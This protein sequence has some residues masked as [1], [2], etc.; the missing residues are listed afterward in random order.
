[1]NI[2]S[3][4]CTNGWKPTDSADSASGTVAGWR[5][6]ALSRLAHPRA[7]RVPS[8]GAPSWWTAST[9][10]DSSGTGAGTA[11]YGA[12][13]RTRHHLIPTVISAWSR[14]STSPWPTWTWRLDDG[15][16]VTQ[17]IIVPHERPAVVVRWSAPDERAP[18]HRPPAPLGPGYPRPPLRE[19]VPCARDAEVHRRA[20]ALAAHTGPAGDPEPRQRHAT[21]TTRSGTGTSCWPRSAIAAST[22]GWICSRP[23]S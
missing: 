1:M 9:A 12:A 2:L 16:E 4:G 14:S 22:T 15:L 3:L 11:L 7:S 10:M 6:R 13:V 20:G 23:G 21:P 8:R 18:A 5:T 17:E 19:S